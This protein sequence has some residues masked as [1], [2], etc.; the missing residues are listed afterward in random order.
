MDNPDNQINTGGG[1]HFEG[2]VDNRD[3]EFVNR[4]KHVHGDEVHQDK[5]M[6]DKYEVHPGGTL[7]AGGEI[8]RLP[9]DDE[10]RAYLQAVRDFYERWADQ[11]DE[12]GLP[13]V[14]Q[15]TSPESGPDAFIPLRALPMR[16]ARFVS[17]P[18][19]Q[20]PPAQDL[21][22][23]L[24]GAQRA[25]ILGEPGS[26]KSTALERIAWAT[27]TNA[28]VQPA[29]QRP[30]VPILIPFSSYSGQPDLL[31]IAD[32]SLK[33][34][35]LRLDNLASLRQWL[36]TREIRI[37]WLLDGLNELRQDHRQDG[38]DAIRSHVIDFP[39]HAVFLTCRTADFDAAA[40][41]ERE[42]ARQVLPEAQVWT[43]EPLVD[44]IRYWSDPDGHSDV[45][46]YLRLYLGH[47][48]GKRLY[49][50][51]QG[52]ARLREM[53]RLPLF[54]WMLK[55][56]G[57]GGG[58]LP[59]DR[60]GLVQR[61][62]KSDRLW[63]NTPLDLRARAERGL[64]RLGW[65]TRELGSLVIDDD[66][67][68]A[69]LETVCG[70][71]STPAALCAALETTGLLIDLQTG[72]HQWHHE[73]IQEYAAAAHLVRQADCG[74]QLAAL[75]KDEA[76]RETCIMAL[77]LRTD[78]HTPQYLQGL[79][80]Q[81][82]VDLRVRIA[83]ATVLAQVGDP[84]FVRR[85]FTV[86][87]TATD[88]QTAARAVEAIEP[89]MISIPAGLAL[90][91]GD[92]PQ[93]DEPDE[94]PQ[95][96]VPVA[97]FELAVYPVTNGEYACFMEDNGYEQADLWTPAGQAWLEGEGKLDSETEAIY[98]N[99]HR[100]LKNDVENTLTT[101]KVTMNLSAEDEDTWR[102][103]ATWDEDDFVNLYTRQ[104]F[105]EQ[106]REPFFWRDSRFNAATQPVVGV[107]W[108]EAMAY[109][110]W[111][112][113]VTGNSYRLPTEAEWEWAARR[114][115]RRYP[116]DDDW[117]AAR[118]NASDSRLG[119]T[120]P[121]G[122]YPHG[123]TPDGLHDMAGNVYE[124]TTTLYR[125]YRYDL[126]DGREDLLADGV[127]VMRGGSWYVGRTNVRCASRDGYIPWRRND[128]LGYRLARASS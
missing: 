44:D 114:N 81:P 89:L 112:A 19:G 62:V 4:D 96:P 35:G 97:A 108:H 80:A 111:L 52:D 18:G 68:D 46:D 41:R 20:P 121:V 90:L 83:A 77:W 66:E 71:R 38:W 37:V 102:T 16:L 125:P 1:A 27:A 49:D 64:E 11:P 28:L 65:R 12:P 95:S 92:D 69:V 115:V 82:A 7:V 93:A 72:N 43:V 25:I 33:R 45:R 51:I 22:A 58:V 36:E 116:W 31:P 118:C 85:P 55:E 94:L 113:R 29:S 30:I 10:V 88:G 5:V 107:N 56:S 91:G 50:R 106:R 103:L 13:L 104:V 26:G 3:G 21:L 86:M 40:Q 99:L 78:L 39:G 57:V 8:I 63:S 61:F 101:L 67:M 84:R 120:S 24:A 100:V 98:R 60:G 105:E 117:D 53:A 6:R 119:Q 47:G 123:A 79:M 54:L 74:Q 122:V 75:A 34:R 9:G 2:D 124:W 73:L 127:R 17:Q 14:E 76:W 70:R 87:R 15:A 23:A 32:Q 126:A 59:V 110:A 42:A 48:D 128:H 109:A